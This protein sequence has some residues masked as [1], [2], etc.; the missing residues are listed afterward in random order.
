M[1]MMELATGL[2]LLAP[3]PSTAPSIGGSC[4]AFRYRHVFLTAAHCVPEETT[5]FVWLNSPGRK[6]AE[7]ARV[8]RHPTADLALLFVEPREEEPFAERHIFG[9][10]AKSLAYG[11]DFVSY[12]YP[13]GGPTDLGADGQRP[14]GRLFKG[15][16]QRYFSH[17]GHLGY[18]YFAGEL[19]IP[20]PAGL[21]GGPV[22]LPGDPPVLSAIVTTNLETY[23]LLDHVEEI[24]EG[25]KTLRV[26]ARRVV[27]YGLAAMLVGDVIQWLDEVVPQVS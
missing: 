26:E 18:K 12:G 10:V 24:Q 16:F 2:V 3:T 21:S 25:G 14:T 22:A 27:S 8:E 7:L 17:E 19:S 1:F 5:V 4:C 15:H 9:D 13:V 23:A 11:G 6:S 20:A